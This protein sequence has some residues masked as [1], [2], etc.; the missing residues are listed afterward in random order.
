MVGDGHWPVVGGAQ[1]V[2]GVDAECIVN[3]GV[4]VRDGDGLFDC[5]FG[6]VV[7]NADDL[8]G[9]EA[10]AGQECAKGGGLMASSAAG[11]ELSGAAELG[12][13]D[14]E[15]GVEQVAGFEVVEQSRE[16]LVEFADELVLLE[17]ALVVGV[18]PGA[19]QEVKV[20]G[21]LDEANAGLDEPA[22]E[23]AALAE[24][25]AVGLAEGGGLAV[26]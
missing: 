24:G 14:D 25:A 3:G 16:S 17:L 20:V 2:A 8:A 10:A 12:G 9:A 21:D 5:L 18:P 1:L 7:G 11:V 4:E 6:E 26:E 22:S 15:G 23:Q 19:V 13:D